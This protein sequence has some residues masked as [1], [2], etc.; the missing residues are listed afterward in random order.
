MLPFNKQYFGVPQD[1]NLK[2][3]D[4]FQGGVFREH[5]SLND[6]I[7]G[8]TQE[9]DFEMEEGNFLRLKLD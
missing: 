8:R 6:I 1:V 9:A 2:I 7:K 4:L 3:I 5:D